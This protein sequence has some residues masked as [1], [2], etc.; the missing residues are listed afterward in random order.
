MASP[1]RLDDRVRDLLIERS[2][3]CDEDIANGLDMQAD[4]I[5]EGENEDFPPEADLP[6]SLQQ[7]LEAETQRRLKATRRREA[8]AAQRTVGQNGVDAHQHTTGGSLTHHGPLAILNLR[9]ASGEVVSG[10]EESKDFSLSSHPPKFFDKD[11]KPT[12][13]PAQAAEGLVLRDPRPAV[14]PPPRNLRLPNLEAS[15]GPGPRNKS[16]DPTQTAVV[17]HSVGTMGDGTGA[18]PAAAAAPGS[19]PRRLEPME[20]HWWPVQSFIPGVQGVNPRTGHVLLKDSSRRSSSDTGQSDCLSR[21]PL[22]LLYRMANE[23]KLP[24]GTV[25]RREEDGRCLLLARPT[26]PASYDALEEE[27]DEEL[28]AFF[29]NAARGVVKINEVTRTKDHVAPPEVH[30]LVRSQLFLKVVEKMRAEL[31]EI[32]VKQLK[33]SDR[34]SAI[35][36]PKASYYDPHPAHHPRSPQHHPPPFQRTTKPHRPYDDQRERDRE[37]EREYRERDRDRRDRQ[38]YDRQWERDRHRASHGSERHR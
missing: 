37:R 29:A 1:F 36:K 8:L 9:N 13:I 25:A 20:G 26:R 22:G 4:F 38:P 18:G 7:V 3:S 19:K 33:R 31:H 32:V 21:A 15:I 10:M 6:L 35:A 11:S 12:P 23:G 5:V 24:A 16:D 14:P 17:P 28:M 2:I 27:N 34:D 30:S